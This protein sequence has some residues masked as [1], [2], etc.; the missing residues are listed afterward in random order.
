MLFLI[1]FFRFSVQS[2]PS[3]W[4]TRVLWGTTWSF[5][6]G[7]NLTSVSTAGSASVR[8]VTAEVQVW[9]SSRNRLSVF[10]KACYTENLLTLLGTVSHVWAYIILVL[11]S[12]NCGPKHFVLQILFP[13]FAWITTMFMFCY[14]LST[15]R[16][17][18]LWMV[19]L[20]LL[21]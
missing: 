21:C 16:A 17:S 7:K 13:A 12:H 6:Q 1:F 18:P 15:S 19:L 9:S 8:K 10:L 2:V 11:H 20:L 3:Y 4:L 14:V 5:T